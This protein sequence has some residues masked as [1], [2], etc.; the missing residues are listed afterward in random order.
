M[1]PVRFVDPRVASLE[2]SWTFSLALCAE[3]SPLPRMCHLKRL[4]GQTFGFYLQAE[5]SSRDLEVLTVEPWSPAEL[6]GLKDGDRILE[7][8]EE[9]V[10]K[11]DLH[12]VGVQNSA[13]LTIHQ[14]LLQI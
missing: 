2:G 9:F 8:N 11:M 12:K 10:D 5:Q 4:E 6:S 14:F 7:V 1:I 3:L 13:D